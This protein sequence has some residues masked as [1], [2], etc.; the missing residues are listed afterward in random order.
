MLARLGRLDGRG[1]DLRAHLGVV[2][3]PAD[4][5]LDLLA[6]QG[7]EDVDQRGAEGRDEGNERCHGAGLLGD[8]FAGRHVAR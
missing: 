1:G 6:G 8:D 7:A 2:A 4:F 5:L 3:V